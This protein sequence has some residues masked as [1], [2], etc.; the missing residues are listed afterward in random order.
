M[1]LEAPSTAT[2]ISASRTTPV[3]GSTIGTFLPE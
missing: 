2:K 3:S 1:S